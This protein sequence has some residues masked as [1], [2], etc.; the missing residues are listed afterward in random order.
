MVSEDRGEHAT[1][2]AAIYSS[3][4]APKIVKLPLPGHEFVFTNE[5]NKFTKKVARKVSFLLG[6]N[7]FATKGTCSN[8]DNNH[9]IKCGSIVG[10]HNGII[11]NDDLL[12]DSFDLPRRGKVDSEVI[13]RL[14]QYS[15]RDDKLDIELFRSLLGE[16][17]G[18]MSFMMVNSKEPYTL[19]AVHGN[20]PL[21]FMAN[22][23]QN[24]VVYASEQRFLDIVLDDFSGW[25]QLHVPPM[26]MAIFNRSNIRFPQISPIKFKIPAK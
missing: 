15:L 8:P 6:H 5:Y 18:Y 2:V 14:A 12:F 17:I 22:E 11:L 13:F 3:E 9:P 23:R 10:T 4:L 16:I 21:N 7:R 24:A 19:I 1:G 26:T 25:R 20:R